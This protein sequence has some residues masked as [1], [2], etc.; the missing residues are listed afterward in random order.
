MGRWSCVYKGLRRAQNPGAAGEQGVCGEAAE[1]D[2]ETGVGTVWGREK[3]SCGMRVRAG[4][5]SEATGLR[6]PWAWSGNFGPA[7]AL[8]PGGATLHPPEISWIPAAAPAGKGALVVRGASGAQ[9]GR[10]PPSLAHTPPFSPAPP[11]EGG[12]H[13]SVGGRLGRQRA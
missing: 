5:G 9:A 6:S 12:H 13:T 1:A 8:G 7:Q 11:P 10:L 4:L 2:G 3:H